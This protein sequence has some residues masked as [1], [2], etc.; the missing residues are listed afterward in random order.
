[1]TR[2]RDLLDRRSFY[3]ASAGLAAIGFNRLASAAE[4]DTGAAITQIAKFKLNMEKEAEGLEALKQLCA[5]VE[6]NEPGVLAYI[7]SRSA[8]N[9]DEIVF[10]EVYKDDEAMKAH[11]KTAHIGKLRTAFVTLF[12]GP[13]EVTR[14]D[15]IGG[16]SR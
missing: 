4:A 3:A 5:A 10:F 8:K 12:R 16:F 11:G 2:V 6:E 13:L 15:R 9:P 7:C 14:L 1:M